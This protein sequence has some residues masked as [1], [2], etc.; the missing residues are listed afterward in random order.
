MLLNWS[1][2]Y[3]P[4]YVETSNGAWFN[5]SVCVSFIS[6][7]YK[8]L[9]LKQLLLTV[10]S[11]IKLFPSP[12]LCV[13]YTVAPLVSTACNTHLGKLPSF[14]LIFWVNLFL[15]SVVTICTTHFNIYKHY[16][17]PPHCTI[18][19]INRHYFPNCV[20]WLV[21]VT[22]VQCVFCEVGIVIKRRCLKH[23]VKSH[24]KQK[25]VWFYLGSS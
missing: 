2:P 13:R 9:Y 8:V 14:Q 12:F 3:T 18:N 1:V 20:N 22:E 19:K 17:Y 21:F 25:K 23:V 7:C 16:I 10:L 5:K 24:T 4:R 15:K 6:C 11:E